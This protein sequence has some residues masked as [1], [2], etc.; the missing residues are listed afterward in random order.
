MSDVSEAIDSGHLKTLKAV[1][2]WLEKYPV[3]IVI[4]AIKEEIERLEAEKK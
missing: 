1:V 4:D 3:Q 2:E